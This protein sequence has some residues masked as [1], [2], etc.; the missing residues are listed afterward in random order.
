LHPA[1]EPT[2]ETPA[3][4]TWAPRFLSPQQND[5]LVA[6]GE[7]IIPGS[8]EALC[9]RLIDSVLLIESEK[10]KSEFLQSLAAFNREAEQLHQRPFEK[11]NPAQQ[12]E[13]IAAS[14]QAGSRMHVEFGILKEWMADAYWS[15]LKGLRELGW[16]GR[17]AWESFP[18][19]KD[20]Q[21]L[22]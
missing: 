1:P 13:I 10:N 8:T 9:N 18:N 14:C 11:L 2:A 12:D 22:S 16:T 19:C 15:S 5:E 3:A 6:L 20:H 7:R 4:T 21:Q 17:V